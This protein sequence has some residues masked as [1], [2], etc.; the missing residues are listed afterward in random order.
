MALASACAVFGFFFTNS[1]GA[2]RQAAGIGPPNSFCVPSGVRV[3][4][5]ILILPSFS[6]HGHRGIGLRQP[7]TLPWSHRGDDGAPCPTP[8]IAT[9]VGLRPPCAST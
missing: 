7:S 6:Q 3:S 4:A 8:M 5:M 1:T 9:S 2:Y